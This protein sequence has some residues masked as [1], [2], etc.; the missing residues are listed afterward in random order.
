MTTFERLY[1]ADPATHEEIK[2]PYYTCLLYTSLNS[3][4]GVIRE[5]VDL[6][7]GDAIPEQTRACLLYTSRCV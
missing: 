7:L 6:V 3:A 4:S 1:V 2:D 5:K